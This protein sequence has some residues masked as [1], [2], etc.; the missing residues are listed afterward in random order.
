MLAS[1]IAATSYVDNTV[2]GGSTYSY[3]ITG[4]DGTGGCESTQSTCSEATAT[5]LCT[6]APT[7][8]GL[9]TATNAAGASCQAN[10]SWSAA[11]P[12]CSGP[13]SYNVY[14]ST[15][16]GFVP[17]PA[18]LIGTTNSTTYNDTNSLINGTTYYYVVRAKDTGN[19]VIE[20]N[21]VQKSVVP[22]GP[23]TLSTL[24]ETFEGAGGFDNAGWTN[25]ALSGATIWTW[26]ATQ[27]QT[28]THS[29][30]ST[31]LTTVSDRVLVSPPF[32][33]NAGTTLSFW[34]TFAF[35]SATTCFDGG[36]LEYTTDGV[37]WTVMPDANFTAGLFNGTVSSSFSN[38]IAGK[39][40]WCNGTIG[41]MTQVQINLASLAGNTVRVRWHAGD[42]SSVAVTGWFVDSVTIAN[43][44][45]AGA[46]T[47]TA[48]GVDVTGRVFSSAEGRGVRNAVVTITDENG[49]AHST[50]TGAL[51]TYRFAEVE[52][53]HTYIVS[54]R[55]RRFTFAPQVVQITDNISGLDFTP[56]P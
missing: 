23:V 8:A 33:V 5:G 15:V 4:K 52:T 27:S 36:T 51:G 30:K 28:P 40:A 53:G 42:D 20:T 55:S 50:V 13:I 16:S 11:S 14:R 43:A 48:S 45:V 38:P 25:Q 37:T 32:G 6:L 17:G 1:N 10:L 47:P 3:K 31:S 54:V 24:T 2:S 7:F 21:T 35:E 34:H 39:R 18:N 12:G 26:D 29:W 44:G 9:T 56:E 49:N 19:N 41:A 46:C 22:S